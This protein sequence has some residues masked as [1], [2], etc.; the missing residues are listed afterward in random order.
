MQNVVVILD[1]EQGASAA[2]EVSGFK[3]ISLIPLKSMGLDLL[4][5]IM[6]DSEW[7]VINDYLHNPEAFQDRSVQKR[8]ALMSRNSKQ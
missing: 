2:A 7:S 1:R 5:G 4:R 8:L 6:H 3:I